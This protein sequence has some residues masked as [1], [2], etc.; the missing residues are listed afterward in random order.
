MQRPR[1]RLLCDRTGYQI[2]FK[3]V[4]LA[5]K[6]FKG[7]TVANVDTGAKLYDAKYMRLEGHRHSALRLGQRPLEGTRALRG[8]P[9]RRAASDVK[10]LQ[11]ERQ[12]ARPGVLRLVSDDAACRLQVQPRCAGRTARGEEND[13]LARLRRR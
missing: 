5:Y 10:P 12:P 8:S 13:R 2:G 9:A 4:E 6:A 3:A 7:E 11:P 1:P